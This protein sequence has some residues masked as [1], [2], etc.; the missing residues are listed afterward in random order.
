M[1]QMQTKNYSELKVKHSLK[2]CK[3]IATFDAVQDL[4]IHWSIFNEMGQS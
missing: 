4:N 3:S 2:E 1:E